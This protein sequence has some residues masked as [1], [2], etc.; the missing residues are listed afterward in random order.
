[1]SASYLASRTLSEELQRLIAAAREREL[2][3]S[4]FLAAPCNYE[5]TQIDYF[6]A[7]HDLR[8]PLVELRPKKRDEI[9]VEFARVLVSSLTHGPAQP[10]A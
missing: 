4:W 3:L 2:L 6:Q 9:Y 1:M 8:R 7:A 5:D 10:S